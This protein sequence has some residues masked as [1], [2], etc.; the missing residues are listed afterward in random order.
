MLEQLIEAVKREF[1]DDQRRI[2]HSLAV[3]KWA[4]ELLRQE[5]AEPGV[6]L[7]AALLHDIGIQQAERKHG[8]S[9]GIYQEREGPPIARRIM[10]RLDMDEETID[11]VCRIV[12]NHHTAGDIDTPEFRILWDADWLVNLPDEFRHADRDELSRR[13]EKIFKTRAGKQ[14]AY[15]L[16][17]H[18]R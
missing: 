15:E 5:E 17:V 9:A 16:F 7:A 18:R 13:I 4:Q 11:H 8:S 1:G 2:T 14:K 10:K 6:V 12:A 3:L